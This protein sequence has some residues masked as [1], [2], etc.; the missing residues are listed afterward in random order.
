[1]TTASKRLIVVL[2]TAV[3]AIFVSPLAAVAQEATLSGTVS[4]A[5][6]GVLPGVTVTATH[7]ESGNTFVAVTSERGVYLLPVRAGHYDITFEL[8][9]FGTTTRREVELLVG[10][11]VL[12]NSELAVST[13]QET[14][15]VSG[16]APLI[17]TT[18]T[19]LGG[20]VDPRQIRDIPVAGR[21]FMDLTL[22]AP[23]S[24][25]N[26]VTEIPAA[27]FQINIDGQQVTQNNN[28]QMGEPRYSM[29]AIA[30]FQLL[31]SRFDATQGRSSGVQLNAIT[32]SGTNQFSGLVAGY[33]RDD[34][35]NAEDFIQKRVLPYSNQQ[36]SSTLGGPLRLNRTHFF[37]NYE[38]QREPKT[39]SYS[40]PYPAFNF[41]QSGSYT[42]VMGGLRLDHQFS[43]DTRMALRGS[44]YTKLEPFDSR[45]SGG[46][47]R[48][49]SS[50]IR[51]ERASWDLNL[52]L[53][54]V[55]STR[56]I[57]EVKSGY[58]GFGW[59]Q[60]S[61]VP[62][63]GGPLA[64]L[65]FTTGTPVINL[66]GYTIG[67]GHTSTP[68]RVAQDRYSVRDDF[69]LT[70]NALGFHTLKMGGEFI[71]DTTVN[72]ATPNATGIYDATGGAVPA[73][74]E[75]LFPVWNDMSTWN[76]NALNP[77]IRSYQIGI[78][79][80]TTYPIRPT[81]AGWFQDDWALSSQLMLNLGL[82]Y[83]YMHNVFAQDTVLPPFLVEPR[84][85]QK[86]LL[87]PR[88]GVSYSVTP[89][90]VIRGGFGK[91][92]ADITKGSFF[93]TKV[94]TQQA[95]VQVLN[96]GRAD[97]ATNPFNGLEPTFEQFLA[98]G[99]RRS[100]STSLSAPNS[101]LPWSYQS[102]IGIQ[103][104][105][106]ETMSIEADYVDTR[107]RNELNSRNVNLSY[108]PATGANYPYTDVSRLPFPAWNIVNIQFTDG[109]SNYHA[110]QTVFTKRFRDRWQASANYAYAREYGFD[111]LPL[112]PGCEYPVTAPGVCTVPITMAPDLASEWYRTGAQAHRA[113]FNGIWQVGHGFQVSGLYFYGDNGKQ[114]ATAGVDT[115]INNTTNGRL[116][117]D[118]TIIP[119]NGIDRA[120]LHRVDLRVQQRFQV[121]PRV[122]VE[123]FV[124][125]FNALNHE[126]YGTYVVNERNAQ[127]GNPSAD[128]GT[129]Y[130]ARTLQL[131]FRTTF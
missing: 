29:D 110:L 14:L 120:D 48:H 96:D 72:F 25:L 104:Q 89:R 116:R 45:Y 90:T 81:A 98:S 1:M 24:R 102:S 18:R 57:N 74:I 103:R 28:Y 61:H 126:N 12:V 105:L 78:G 69:T 88:I 49:P 4:D 121:G 21:N 86:D 34:S 3:T 10:A 76:L 26:S 119:R 37:A 36:I 44:R 95:T 35:M 43:P 94:S 64:G 70:S 109:Q 50:A 63:A 67:Q 85:N 6:G 27:N 65:G 114:T 125:V 123:G 11:K 16:E 7:T 55:L 30:E 53:T 40:S 66:R 106:G 80:F 41:D 108:N 39:F 68:I 107:S 75:S 117:A 93:A 42:Q 84:P 32:K 22:L 2:A 82:R 60:L 127:F 129:A 124:D 83:D 71:Y 47:S 51:T 87:G 115:R 97:F 101:R 77:V 23:G 56:A 128:T 62:W 46:A 8:P 20:N 79:N 111:P 13:V 9:G 122:A 113:I 54:Q 131:G 130:Q 112:L 58:A 73:N 31:S 100:L 59:N 19:S 15:T 52:T 92:Y 17:D 33:F 91:Y 5:T 118:G 38:W 99:F